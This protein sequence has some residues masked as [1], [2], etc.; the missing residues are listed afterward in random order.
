MPG[1]GESRG[2][3]SRSRGSRLRAFFGAWSGGE[4][5]GQNPIWLT[6]YSDMITNLTLFFL[7]MFAI[8]RLGLDEQAS[9]IGALEKYFR[10]IFAILFRYFL[11]DSIFSIF[12]KNSGDWSKK[13]SL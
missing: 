5:R 8:T 10:L 7:M 9:L 13:D 12:C 4:R 3:N 11:K 2:D 1:Q 6:V